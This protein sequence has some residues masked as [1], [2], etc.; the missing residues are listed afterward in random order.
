MV[1][2]MLEWGVIIVMNV[3][4]E[5]DMQNAKSH[6]FTASDAIGLYRRLRARGQTS[7]L[8]RLS[9]ESRL[10]DLTPQERKTV[11]QILRDAETAAS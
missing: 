11:R 10:S 5:V 1:C 9:V 7:T 4:K 8:A 3:S 6:T 2:Y